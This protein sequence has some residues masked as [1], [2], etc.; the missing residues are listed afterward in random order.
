MQYG[1][2]FRYVISQPGGF[3]QLLLMS[4]CQLIPAV[5][6]IVLNGYLAILS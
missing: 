5:G 3:V 6:P 1:L 4:V 2:A